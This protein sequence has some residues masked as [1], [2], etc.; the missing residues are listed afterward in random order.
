VDNVQAGQ[1]VSCS[2]VI[3][4]Q[5]STTLPDA[6]T[7]HV[8]VQ[9]VVTSS[10]HA[11]FVDGFNGTNVPSNPPQPGV[12]YAAS[13]NTTLNLSSHGTD[14]EDEANIRIPL[15]PVAFLPTVV[16][17]TASL[18]SSISVTSDFQT[19][20]SAVLSANSVLS[21]TAV[22]NPFLGGVTADASSSVVTQ[23]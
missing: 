2:S 4:D 22:T 5:G 15:S 18:N 10:N 1:Y 20:G 12:F 9:S 21:Q 17:A 13:R 16:V 11:L 3:L 19:N 14:A 7:G 8:A 23:V 6:G